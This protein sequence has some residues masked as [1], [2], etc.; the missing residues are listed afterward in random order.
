M[1]NLMRRYHPLLS[2]MIAL[3]V[4]LGLFLYG[5]WERRPQPRAEDFMSIAIPVP[6]QMLYA[7]GDRFLAANIGAWR[8][9]VVGTQKLPPET[10][11]ALAKVQ[12]DVS[13]L[14]PRHEDNYYTAAAILP[15]EGKV[16][17]AQT[18]LWRA[19]EALPEDVYPPFYYGFN[20]AHF[21]GDI[22]GAVQ[23]FHLAAQHAQDVG[24]RQ[25]LTVIAAKWSEKADDATLAVQMVRVM[26]EGTRDK[27]LKEYLNL[28][29]ER[30]EQLKVLRE[31]QNQYLRS[32]GKPLNEL[33]DLVDAGILPKMPED[34]L[35]GGFALKNNTIV[36]LPATR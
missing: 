36:L 35:G 7:A 15:W 12:E 17:S 29:I 22:P 2:S 21:L 10:L 23:A 30:L 25:A 5:N 26:A 9:I 27:A 16:A 6:M 20:Q 34:P 32:Q 14:N 33:S 24:T 1:A 28:R 31:A 18:V 8:A 11:S 4:G 3:G 13:W 19:S